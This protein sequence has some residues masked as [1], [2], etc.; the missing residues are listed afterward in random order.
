MTRHKEEES[1]NDVEDDTSC[2][3]ESV[4][5]SSTREDEPSCPDDQ[6]DTHDRD[7]RIEEVNEFPD[8]SDRIVQVPLR[9]GTV[10]DRP[11]REGTGIRTGRIPIDRSY[12]W[13]RQANEEESDTCI[14]EYLESLFS[15][16][17]II[18]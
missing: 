5:F 13:F 11:E 8:E 16:S 15:R 6:E 18:P 1:Q 4:A 14:E 3:L 17:I 12:E 10:T 2:L 9:D 7:K